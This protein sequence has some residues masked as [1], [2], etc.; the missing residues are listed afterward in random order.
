MNS[1]L[2]IPTG[3][4]EPEAVALQ[5]LAAGKRV[6]EVGALLGFSTVILAQVADEVASVDPHDG[7][8]FNDPRDTWVPFNNNLLRYGVADKVLTYRDRYTAR[9]AALIGDEWGAPNFAFLDLDGTYE[10]TFKVMELVAEHMAVPMDDREATILAVHDY[11]LPE[12]PGAGAAIRDYC[13]QTQTH[14]GLIDTL[15]LIRLPHPDA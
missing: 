3:L 6:L 12:W 11:G 10:N 5:Q 7:Y 15:A 8:P 13:T 14:F 1:L 9:T 4:T 2:D